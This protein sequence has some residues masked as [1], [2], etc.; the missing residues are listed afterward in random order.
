MRVLNRL[1]SLAAA[2]TVLATVAAFEARHY[3]LLELFVHFRL[4]WLVLATALG[5]LASVRRQPVWAVTLGACAIANAAAAWAYLPLPWRT[6]PP[7]EAA[8]VS[9]PAAVKV[10][11]AN[12]WFHA[13]DPTRLLERVEQESP[14]V[15]VVVEFTGEWYQALEPLRARYPYR[16]EDPSPR[17]N[18]IAIYSRFALEGA[19]TFELSRPAIEARVLAPGGTFTLYGVHLRSPTSRWYAYLRSREYAALAARLAKR[20]GPVVVTGDFNTSPFSPS[21]TKW[22]ATTGLND[23]R[24]GRGYIATWPTFLPFLGIP[25][26]HCVVS[27]ELRIEDFRRLAPFGSDHAAIVTEVALRADARAAPPPAVS[28]R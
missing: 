16:L 20:T 22:L 12:L 9:S 4:Q 26:D 2:G 13:S 5:L 7:V 14:D 10:L 28:A 15:I 25:I 3:W 1:I 8:G 24:L 11:T 23:A 27:D 18:G 21:F 17:A 19:T 6:S